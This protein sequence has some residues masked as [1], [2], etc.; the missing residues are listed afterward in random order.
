MTLLHW[1]ARTG[2]LDRG[3][4]IRTMTLP[5]AFIDHASPDAM[6]RMAGLTAEDI[7]TTSLQALGVSAPA[8]RRVRA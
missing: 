5:D 6:Y 7:A 2:R 3:L 4:A 8:F 1:L